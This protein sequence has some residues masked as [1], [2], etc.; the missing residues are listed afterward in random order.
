MTAT[1]ALTGNNPVTNAAG[2]AHQ[3]VDNVAEKAA[4][5]VQTAAAKAHETIDRA[6]S[7]GTSAAEWAKTNGTQ[8]AEKSGALAEVCS[9]YVK[10]RPF[11]TVAGAL[12]IGYLFGRVMR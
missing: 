1:T 5:V 2:R 8:I 6:A 4:P 7:A 10:A 11:V 3:M 12:A 9:G